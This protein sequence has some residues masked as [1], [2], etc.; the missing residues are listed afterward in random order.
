MTW[1]ISIL[2]FAL[3]SQAQTLSYSGQEISY[4]FETE[5]RTPSEESL[6]KS[7]SLEQANLHADHLFGI[8]HSPEYASRFGIPE[9]LNDGYAGTEYPEVSEVKTFRQDGDSHIWIKYKAQAKALVRKEVLNGWIGQAKEGTI[10]LPLLRDLSQIYTEDY[11]DYTKSKWSKCTDSHYSTPIDFYYFYNPFLCTEL[12]E[13]PLASN[14]NFQIQ[15]NHQS[16][17]EGA[18]IPTQK[19]HGDNG[20][21]KLV[22]LYFAFGYNENP[23][24]GSDPRVIHRDAGWKLFSSI[25]NNL[26][27]FYGFKKIESEAELSEILGK[28]RKEI[29]LLTPV[30]MDSNSKRIYFSTYVK[31]DGDLI[32]VARLGLFNTSNEDS[33]RPLKSFPKFWKEAWENADFIYY[34]GHSGDGVSLSF[35]TLMSI[36]SKIDLDSIRFKRKK[37]QIVFL[38]AC[39]SYAHYKNTYVA[40]HPENLFLISHGLTTPFHLAKP[41]LDTMIPMLLQDQQEPSWLY[42]LEEV[43]KNSLLPQLQFLWGEEK[44][45]R[46]YEK[47]ARE[48]QYPSTLINV[49]VPEE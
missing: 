32:Y 37:T 6:T 10:T 27:E 26:K 31:F 38:D 14:V 45:G 49:W 43:E 12:S 25:G 48:K 5:F 18:L 36:Y 41:M 1:I 28:D 44:G 21:G 13:P 33:Y 4:S 19:I 39:S 46:L 23:E 9:D 47:Y 40:K 3:S 8:F 2:F 17:N 34:G 16:S 7:E 29:D 20:N 42:L 30:N 35:D 22:N 15:L 11:A 24:A